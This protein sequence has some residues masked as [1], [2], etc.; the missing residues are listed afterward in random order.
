MFHW[1]VVSWGY[2]GQVLTMQ[3]GDGWN[4]KLL[5]TA[6]VA[7]I[8]LHLLLGF[9]K[10][11]SHALS[12]PLWNIYRWFFIIY[13][14]FFPWEDSKVTLCLSIFTQVSF[15]TQKPWHVQRVKKLAFCVCN[16]TTSYWRFC[17]GASLLCEGYLLQVRHW[18][19]F[20]FQGVNLTGFFF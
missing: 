19:F 17:A 13:V 14:H 1:A 15:H 6:S 4:L 10:K 3:I 11:P 12:T 7:N 9:C 16:E 20:P 2:Q 5:H 18:S 8:C